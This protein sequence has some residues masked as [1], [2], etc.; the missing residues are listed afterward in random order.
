MKNFIIYPL[1]A[2]EAHRPLVLTADENQALAR[3][4]TPV[5]DVLLMV[6]P[7]IKKLVDA[8]K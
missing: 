8:A 7:P 3:A 5:A 6:A 4:D 2:L 1:D